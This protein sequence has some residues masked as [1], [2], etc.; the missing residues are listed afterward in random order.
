MSTG[1]AGTTPVLEL[2]HVEPFVFDKDN[3][4]QFKF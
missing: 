2:S 1:A 3:I 4:D